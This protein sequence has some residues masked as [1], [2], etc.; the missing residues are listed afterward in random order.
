MLQF[1]S[2]VHPIVP[3][4]NSLP[5]LLI[6]LDALQLHQGNSQLALF[7]LD[8][9]KH[10]MLTIVSRGHSHH[11]DFLSWLQRRGCA[12]NDTPGFKRKL[13]G[14]VKIVVPAH[15]LFLR[16]MRIHNDFPVDALFTCF[17]FGWASHIWKLLHIIYSTAVLLRL[18]HTPFA[19]RKRA[20]SFRI[21]LLLQAAEKRITIEETFPHYPQ[22]L[23]HL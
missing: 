8:Q 21:Y 13:Q 1:V 14:I 12:A 19:R 17:I 20:S 6:H 2:P 15:R 3:I 7:P 11:L 23:P 18:Y 22:P 5:G 10:F 9:H 16:V 4:L